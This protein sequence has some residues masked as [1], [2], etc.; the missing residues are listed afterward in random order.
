M[1]EE[2]LVQKK[3]KN[4]GPCPRIDLQNLEISICATPIIKNVMRYN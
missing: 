1:F 3:H 4:Q 2:I